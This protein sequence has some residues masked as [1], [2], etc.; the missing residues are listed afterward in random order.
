MF[1][2]LYQR[3][4][5]HSQRHCGVKKEWTW[6]NRDEVLRPVFTTLLLVCFP[7]G[8]VERQGPVRSGLQDARTPRNVVLRPAV[9]Y[10]GYG[11]LAQNGQ[12]GWNRISLERS[13]GVTKENVLFSSFFD[14][15]RLCDVWCRSELGEAYL[16]LIPWHLE[17]RQGGA[18]GGAPA[19][20]LLSCEASDPAR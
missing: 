19:Q 5:P 20:L 6:L 8:E 13:H 2:Y 16:N 12:E 7:A 17:V 1:P 9:H 15:L 18:G 4:S 10:Q 14:Y 3:P 11:G